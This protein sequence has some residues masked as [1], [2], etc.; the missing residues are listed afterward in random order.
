MKLS[1]MLVLLAGVA[2]A[3]PAFGPSA[4]A[5]TIRPGRLVDAE[6]PREGATPAAEK[7]PG[8]S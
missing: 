6:P 4:A 1:A 5:Q 7:V 3:M 2:V 8:V